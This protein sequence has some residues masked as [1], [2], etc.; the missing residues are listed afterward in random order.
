MKRESGKLKHR[1]V[2]TMR[3]LPIW[4]WPRPSI[5]EGQ[6][7][8]CRTSDG[9]CHEFPGGICGEANGIP[10]LESIFIALSQ[11]IICTANTCFPINISTDFSDSLMNGS[12]HDQT[13][14]AATF[15]LRTGSS[16][17][18]YASPTAH[19]GD[20]PHRPSVRWIDRPHFSCRYSLSGK[21][22]LSPSERFFRDFRWREAGR[23]CPR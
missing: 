23:W 17:V 1:A 8:C 5:H 4:P 12:R 22:R 20:A 18:S 16:P 21:R 11:R 13:F 2:G 15:S 19:L 9:D 10:T 6:I 7:K 14:P 3:R